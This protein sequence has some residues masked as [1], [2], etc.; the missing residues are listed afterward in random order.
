MMRKKQGKDQNKGLADLST[1]PW[2]S[3]PPC[4]RT[5]LQVGALPAAGDS[6]LGS[7]SSMK[8]QMGS[9]CHNTL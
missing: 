3:R 9:G 8:K 1:G 6:R 4:Q 7:Q 2:A 5:L